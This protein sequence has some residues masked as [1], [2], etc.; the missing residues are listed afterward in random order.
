[1]PHVKYLDDEL[2]EEPAVDAKRTHSVF[3]EDWK[4]IE[5]LMEDGTVLGE[6]EDSDQNFSKNL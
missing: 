1:M 5:E 3:D 2:L 6:V 4:L